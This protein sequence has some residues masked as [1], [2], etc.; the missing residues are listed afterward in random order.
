MNTPVLSKKFAAVLSFLLLSACGGQGGGGADAD[1]PEGQAFMYRDSV[2]TI[3]ANKMGTIG[4]MAR[5]EIP[6][7][8]A[9]FTKAVNDLTSVAGMVTEG[10]MPEG[11]PSGSRSLPEIWTNWGDFEQKAQDLQTAAQGLA[12]AV[13]SGGFAAAQGLVQGTAGTCG[14]CHRMYRERTE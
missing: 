8:E 12:D 10:F 5:E 2:M 4:G 6:L 3:L 14:G 1:T 7:D 9:V 13:S 11:I